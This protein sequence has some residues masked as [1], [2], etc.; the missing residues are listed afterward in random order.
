MIFVAD[1]QR[2]VCVRYGISRED[3]LSPRRVRL[4]ARPRQV[5]MYLAHRITGKSKHN[6]GHRF[7][8]RDHS[9]VSHGI[10]KI[11]YLRICDA[12][13]DADVRDLLRE[14]GA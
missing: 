11:A 4:F 9:T 13:L 7:G 3:M 14:F 5:A 2:R 1:I 6:I 10:D 8:G 12:A